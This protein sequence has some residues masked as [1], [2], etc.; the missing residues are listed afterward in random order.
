MFHYNV[1]RQLKNIL[2]GKKSV[3]AICFIRLLIYVI[4]IISNTIN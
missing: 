4:H 3:N 2:S 1:N